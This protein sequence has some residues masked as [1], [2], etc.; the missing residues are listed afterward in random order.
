MKLAEL[1]DLK[2]N[3]KGTGKTNTT[4]DEVYGI[5]YRIYCIPEDK[6][7]IG[8]TYSH[9]T[10]RHP[11]GNYYWTRYGY[12]NRCKRHYR[13]R[14]LELN[15]DKPLYQALCE[16]T[17][18]DFE[19]YEEKKV[20]GKDLARFNQIEGEYIEKYNSLSPDGYNIEEVGK[21][22]PPILHKLAQHYN[23]E[24]EHFR[25]VDKT[26]NTRGKDVCFGT[27]FNL[28]K[29][30]KYEESIIVDSLKKI[31][32]EYIR[33]MK[34]RDILRLKDVYRLLAKVNQDKHKHTPQLF[35][36]KEECRAVA[37]KVGV[38]II[39]A[40]SFQGIDSCYQYQNKLNKILESQQYH[41]KVT[42]MI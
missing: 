28:E 27:F 29:Q 12:I 33:L 38:K 10:T 36:S 22:Y 19:I 32:L 18:N 13:E 5:I 16:Y 17:L 42:L 8:Q 24:I 30:P 6:S 1:L 4:I 21:K 7:Y 15:K 40:E 37:E 3:R 34:T 25:Y 31:P 39:E 35:N 2:Y 14:E 23:F 26:R 9:K 11:N 20:T 41:Q